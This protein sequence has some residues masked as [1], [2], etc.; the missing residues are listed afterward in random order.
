MTHKQLSGEDCRNLLDIINR[1]SAKVDLLFRFLA[2][3]NDPH[4]RELLAEVARENLD[5]FDTI[6][7]DYEALVA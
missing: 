6:I 7:Q 3:T 4:E 1:Q 5:G 2:Q